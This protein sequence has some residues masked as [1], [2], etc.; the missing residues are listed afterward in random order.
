MLYTYRRIPRW[1][2]VAIIFTSF[3]AI[4]LIFLGSTCNT[5]DIW[6]P[7]GDSC[8]FL[9]LIVSPFMLTVE[10]IWIG[11]GSTTF[12]FENNVPLLIVGGTVTWFLIFTIVGYLIHLER[13][14]VR[15]H[16]ARHKLPPSLS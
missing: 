7:G 8:W 9:W 6:G 11:P 15:L 1:L 3:V 14:A 4:A 5:N 10:M 12:S 13:R 16:R 2:R